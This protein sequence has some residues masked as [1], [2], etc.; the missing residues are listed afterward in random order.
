M[1][2]YVMRYSSGF[3]NNFLDR[4]SGWVQG[5]KGLTKKRVWIKAKCGTGDAHI[6][7]VPYLPPHDSPSL[8]LWLGAFAASRLRDLM[9]IQLQTVSRFSSI[10]SLPFTLFS[11]VFLFVFPFGCS[12]HYF[13]PFLILPSRPIRISSFPICSSALSNFPARLPT[14]EL[15]TVTRIFHDSHSPR[16]LPL[17][18]TSS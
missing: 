3:S 7:I 14:I 11:S 9:K 5:L 18:Q 10:S 17:C 13:F 2:E 6:V 4:W 12:S 1:F 8:F 15:S 16:F